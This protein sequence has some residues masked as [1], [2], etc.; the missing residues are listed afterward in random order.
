MPRAKNKNFRA[1]V[2]EFL[3]ARGHKAASFD[4]I[5]Q[6]VGGHRQQVT[7]ALY[8]LV[9]LGRVFRFDVQVRPPNRGKEGAPRDD[10]HRPYFV[11]KEFERW[12]YVD[13]PYSLPED[14][15]PLYAA[16]GITPPA[17]LR[18]TPVFRPAAGRE[19]GEEAYNRYRL[20]D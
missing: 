15:A 16:W 13:L 4:E 1:E 10:T 9:D 17:T 11:L 19:E 5:E 14:I 20:E 6:A 18:R 12:A 7:F 2:W 8:D 3:H